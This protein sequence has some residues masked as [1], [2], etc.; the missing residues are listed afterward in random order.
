MG[1]TIFKIFI[2]GGI[3]LDIQIPPLAN[4]TAITDPDSQFTS[5]EH[6]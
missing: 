2:W 5:I 6:S 4:V 3:S 1:I